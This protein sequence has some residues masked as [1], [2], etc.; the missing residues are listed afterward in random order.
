MNH[1]YLDLA[2]IVEPVQFRHDAV[3]RPTQYASALMT[4]MPFRVMTAY[5]VAR[6]I[7]ARIA[8]TEPSQ[9]AKLA[10]SG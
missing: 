3:T 7:V 9:N 1:V 2:G 4:S 8:L 6:F 10:P 5:Q